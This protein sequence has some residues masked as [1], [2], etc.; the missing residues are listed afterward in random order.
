MNKK[1]ILFLLAVLFAGSLV[2]GVASCK[3][4]DD[5][6]SESS[7][8][9]TEAQQDEA[10]TFWDVV[11]QL[12]DVDDYTPD[13]A[14]ATFE[15]TI[16]EA[17]DGS[18][19]RVVSTND[20]ASAA[21]R[22]NALI[23]QPDAVDAATT[24]YTWSHP[25][26]GTLT[27]HQGTGNNLATVD[28]DIPQ[29]PHLQQIAY[30]SPQQSDEN[31]SFSGAAYY[32][33]GDVISRTYRERGSTKEYTEYWICVRP[34]FGPEGKKESHW[35]S[36]SPLPSKN[37]DLVLNEGRKFYVPT[38]I[39]TN[40]EHMQNLAELLYAMSHPLHWERNVRDIPA[41]GLFSKGLRMFHDFSHKPDKLKYHNRFFFQRVCD[42]WKALGLFSAIFGFDDTDPRFQDFFDRDHVLHLL[43]K[44]HSGLTSSSDN[45]TLYEYCYTNN[46]AAD[47]IKQNM[48]EVTTI[49]HRKD[50][51][52]LK[53]TINVSALTT[54]KPYVV[55]EDYFDDPDPR[56]VIRHA[57]GKELS[58]NGKYNHKEHIEGARGVYV[59]ND[60]YYQDAGFC[61][62][63]QK[64]L[65]VA[66]DPHVVN[67]S[68][69]YNLSDFTGEPYY[70]G[71]DV[72]QD[73]Y[74]SRW[75][76][77][78]PAGGMTAQPFSYFVTF[79]NVQ[80][81][82]TGTKAL[83]LPSLNMA[84]GL[85]NVMAVCCLNAISGKRD[86]NSSTS[87]RNISKFANVD[88][89]QFA[90]KKDTLPPGA[91]SVDHP[92]YFSVA[93]DSPDD[94]QQ[95]CRIIIDQ[96]YIKKREMYSLCWAHYLSQ[97]DAD[98]HQNQGRYFT[99]TPILLKDVCNQDIVDRLAEDRYVRLP[100]SGQ[101]QR[102][103][104]RTQAEDAKDFRVSDYFWT[105]GAFATPRRF[106]WN[107]RVLFFRVLKIYDR[108][109]E[110]HALVSTGGHKLQLVSNVFSQD[111]TNFVR[112][113][114]AL[115]QINNSFRIGWDTYTFFL[116]GKEYK[117]Q[118]E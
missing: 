77:A 63:D 10:S 11:G 13:Y 86:V 98:L 93:Y 53:Q 66:V 113:T 78:L 104:I 107:D 97:P 1:S 39:G 94:H 71:G 16:G 70:N 67:D 91:T 60:Y 68:E 88:F 25:A 69:H 36:L 83:D 74:G 43:A 116:D 80:L 49:T 42:A 58:N 117:P 65:E 21:E 55:N 109:E 110:A 30:R 56:Y 31:G 9:A 17:E 112:E 111:E 81:N 29:V 54:K 62:L 103:P 52:E 47:D 115:E 44:G 64:E 19:V 45:L 75:F 14:N 40:T 22:F 100:L 34:A 24:E 32:R 99:T 23:G 76:C 41:P 2:T 59:Y 85:G 84:F 26:V 87:Y 79:D 114:V 89:T 15:P 95:V 3:D 106:I 105:N 18:F 90:E 72:Y 33:F 37:C 46:T 6:G 48:H 118:P 8:P 35:V 4:D 20:L 5:D 96:T 7:S 57:T 102:Q 92:I 12:V 108:G 61:D 82:A 50:V 27:Y 51:S 28:V 101:T 38:G 73:Q